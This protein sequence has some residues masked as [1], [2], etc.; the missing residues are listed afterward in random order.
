MRG[1][2]FRVRA[3]FLL[4]C[5]SLIVYSG[6]VA[7]YAG[8]AKGR[9]SRWVPGEIIVKFKKG[10][11]KERAGTIH[12]RHGTKEIYTSP[13][14]GFKRLKVPHGKKLEEILEFYKGQ[15]DV[16]YAGLNYYAH[17]HQTPNDP[18]YYIQWH[19]ND[20]VAGIN[21]EPAWDITTGDP[22]VIIAVLDTGIAYENYHEYDKA[23]DFANTRFVTGKDYIN[24]DNHANDDEGHGTHVAGT[25]A[26]STN[27]GV[28]VAGVA[29]NCTIMPVK[30]LDEYGEGSYSDIADGIYWAV[31]NGAKI[32][33]MSLGGPYDSPDLWL[34]VAYAYNN[35]VTVIC[36][37]GN[38]YEDGNTPSYP[39]AYDQYC[40]AVGATIYDLTRA[41]YSNTG[42]YL[43]LAAPG[44]IWDTDQNGDGYDDGVYQQTVWVDPLD[45]D[46]SDFDYLF[47]FGTSMAAP[48]V[49]GVAALLASTGVMEP[50]DIREALE[51]SARDLGTAGWDEEF[52]HGLIDAY[53]ALAY[54]NP[55]V[56]VGDF[57]GNGTVDYEDLGILAAGWLSDVPAVDI[58]PEGGDGTVNFLDFAAFAQNWDGI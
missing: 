54:F 6:V 17:A 47:Y 43:D 33:N 42:N 16:E 31:D 14:S 5:F 25:I 48:H 52:G 55:P 28:G 11:S 2:F 8:S 50:D 57:S 58:A 37:A 30:V 22:N 20:P 10:V 39:A 53:A 23:P 19:F 9:A 7:V 4:F 45:P 40:I 18:R 3:F 49:T 38:E 34:A 21:I 51:N 12:S 29:Y 13:F 1:E 46:Y 26:Q 32:I 44:G 15:S 35:G 27:N 41:S 24:Y 36:S 56:I